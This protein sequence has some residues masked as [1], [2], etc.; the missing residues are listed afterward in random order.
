MKQSLKEIYT[1]LTEKEYRVIAPCKIGDK[2]FFKQAG[3]YEDIRMDYVNPVLPAKEWFFPVT[4]VVMEYKNHLTDKVEVKDVSD[5]ETPSA[6]IGVRPCDAR[7][8]LIMDKVFSWD[9]KDDFYLKRRANTLIVTIACDEQAEG[10]F[11]D[12]FGIGIDSALGADI[13]LRKTEDGKFDTAIITENG[14]KIFPEEKIIACPES[15]TVKDDK[16]KKWLDDNFEND[17]WKEIS[18][19]CLGCGACAFVCPTCHCF[20]IV[21]EASFNQGCRI[22]NW[23]SCGF[24]HF[25]LH[26]SGHNP[27]PSQTERF[28]NRI[29]HKFKYYPDKFNETACVGC[30]RCKRACPI[31]MDLK[32]ILEKI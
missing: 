7:S 19:K 6:I 3:Q 15:I 17:L 5:L 1:K 29:M 24:G 32:D 25:T 13:L 30:G 22:K 23:D 31:K 27:R 12:R 26:T 28:R 16:L 9:Y 8:L 20:D 2:F 4:E 11:C 21:D 18:Q 14:K 10:C